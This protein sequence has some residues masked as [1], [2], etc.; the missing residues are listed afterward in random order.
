MKAKIE[1][2][3][4]NIRSYEAKALRKMMYVHG[5]TV[6]GDPTEWE[7]SSSN[8]KCE[9]FV[10]GQEAEFTTEVTEK[11]GFTNRKIVPIRAPKPT[12][13]GGGPG[14]RDSEIITALSAASTAAT[15]CASK[16]S[17]TTS[18]MLTLAEQVY[19]WAMSKQPK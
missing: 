5:I 18:D 2:V 8:A 3:R 17:A 15:F 7:Y 6:A 14:K 9:H 16:P 13:G 10:P 12:F 19:T 4:E 1:K 11:G